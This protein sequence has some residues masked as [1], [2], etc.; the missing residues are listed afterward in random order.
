MVG[1]PHCTQQSVKFL[2]V[3]VSSVMPV[4]I[5]LA[6]THRSVHVLV[7]RTGFYSGEIISICNSLPFHPLVT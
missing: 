4:K 6:H 1:V 5:L 3:L 2:I 7:C